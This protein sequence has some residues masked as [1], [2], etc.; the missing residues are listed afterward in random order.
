MPSRRVFKTKTFDRWARKL[1]DDAA[2]CVAAREIEAGLYEADLGAG[3]C[4]KRIATFGRGKRASIRTLVAKKNVH[5]VIFLAGRE[6]SAPGAD[7]SET[8]VA[9]AKNIAKGLEQADVVMLERLMAVGAL[10]EMC[11]DE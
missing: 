7:F 2:L 11:D 5:A 1:V 8:E 9:V 4:K 10:K 6:K 3:L